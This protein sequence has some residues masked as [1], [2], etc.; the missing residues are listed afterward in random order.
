MGS[1]LSKTFSK[2]G[3]LLK[4]RRLANQLDQKTL[5]KRA[6]TS[7]SQISRIERGAISPSID[8]LE[9]LFQA[10]DEELYL[11]TRKK[12]ESHIAPAS[13]SGSSLLFP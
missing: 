3:H 11:S 9:R 7:P 13:S 10:M 12:N 2:A 4:E 5:A 8:T 6:Q 1:L